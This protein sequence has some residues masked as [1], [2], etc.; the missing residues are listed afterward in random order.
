M[1]IVLF[2]DL[3]LYRLALAPWDLI[4]KRLLGQTNL[5]FH[6]SSR[7]DRSL[8]A[9]TVERI[10]KLEPDLVLGSGDLT[11][12]A[13]AAEFRDAHVALA[14]LL[15][16]LPTLIIPGNHD[17]YTFTAAARRRFERFFVGHC[18]TA[19]PHHQILSDDLHLIALNASKPNV[20][21][22][23]GRMGSA[24]LQGL[25]DLLGRIATGVRLIVLCHYTLGTPPRSKPE[26]WSHVMTDAE[27]VTAALGESGRD[28]LYCH[29]HV[30][31][32]WCWRLSEAANIMTLNAGA[33]LH[34]GTDH[35]QGQGFWQIET[36][37]GWNLVRHRMDR[38]RQWQAREIAVPTEA[39]GAATLTASE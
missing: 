12:T 21:L 32:P 6:R 13:T 18:P 8:L 3:H 37:G 2:G 7:F 35:P 19:F 17:R 11:T 27:Q 16:R 28:V 24:Q 31:R 22:D 30:H 29:G 36:D 23:R 4:S 10:A 38:N 9:P 15:D 5:W 26:H 34:I 1:R 39:D 33:P 20:L 25:R 14:P